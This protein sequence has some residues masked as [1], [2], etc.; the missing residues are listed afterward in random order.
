MF[1]ISLRTPKKFFSKDSVVILQ[2]ATT[3]DDA[4]LYLIWYEQRKRSV[5]ITEEDT[6]H[7]IK[8]EKES[9][10]AEEKESSTAS[11]LV[12][13]KKNSEMEP[14]AYVIFMSNTVVPFLEHVL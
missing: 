14:Q 4:E 11:S 8:G 7:I 2:E 1:Y 5:L 3:F 10:T 6:I 12:L 13:H 9:S